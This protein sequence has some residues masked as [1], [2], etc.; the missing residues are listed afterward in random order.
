MRD[1]AQRKSGHLTGRTWEV[2]ILH[3]SSTDEQRSSS[4]KDRQPGG[5]FSGG[6]LAALLLSHRALRLCFLRRALC[7]PPARKQ[8]AHFFMT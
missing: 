1:S 8:R 3:G 4:T 5:L 6:R 2:H 7:Q